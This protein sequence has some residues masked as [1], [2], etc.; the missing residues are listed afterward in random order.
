MRG[1]PAYCAPEIYYG[2]LFSIKSD[3]YAIA[4]I[5]WEIVSRVI[6]AEYRRPYKEYPNLFNDMV[7][8]IQAARNG[9]RPTIPPTTPELLT[10]LIKDCWNEKPENRPTDCVQIIERLQ[11]LE[12]DWLENKENWDRLR[13]LPPAVQ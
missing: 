3:I 10:N 6:N 8:F 7:I 12:K 1:T 9:L 2:E 5:L 11:A 4:I 13:V